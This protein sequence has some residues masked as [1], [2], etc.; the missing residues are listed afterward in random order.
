MHSSRR[1]TD[2]ATIHRPR[3]AALVFILITVALDI[4]AMGMVI[5]VLPRL[6]AEFMGGDTA[7]AARI[8][9]MFGTVWALMQ[10]LDRKSTRLNSSHRT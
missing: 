7:D 5:P 2:P 1:M 10:F 8:F 4:L 3:Q 6:V 9:G